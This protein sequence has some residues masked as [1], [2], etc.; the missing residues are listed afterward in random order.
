MLI[1]E[2]FVLLALD[3][4]GTLARGSSYQPVVAV[5]VT[6]ALVSELAV[7]G[8]VDLA[9]G[10][11]RLTGSRPEHPLLAQVLDNLAPFEGKKLKSRLSSIKHSGWPEVVDAM[12]DAGVLGRERPALRPTRHPPVDP[13]GHAANLAEVRAAAQADGPLAPELAVLLAL[14]GPCHLLE[15]VAPD[16]ATRRHARRRIDAA[17][18]LVPAAG[19]VKAAIEAVQV[20]ATVAATTAA[21]TS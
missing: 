7:D 14:A 10:R 6:G 13:G 20:A 15:V 3:E 19:A 8:H 11:I 16:R 18:D 17:A 12:V 9:D 5:G 21:T 4:D 1:A 2:R